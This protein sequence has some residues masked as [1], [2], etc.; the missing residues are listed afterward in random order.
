MNR[1]NQY[2]IIIS[3]LGFIGV[4]TMSYLLVLILTSPSLWQGIAF[5]IGAFFY[6]L[7]VAIYPKYIKLEAEKKNKKDVKELG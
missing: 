4:F 6:A 5:C 2:K 1:L 3:L 7:A